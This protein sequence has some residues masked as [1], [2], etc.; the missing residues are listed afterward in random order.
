MPKCCPLTR[1]API[2][3]GEQESDDEPGLGSVAAREY[4]S[5]EDWSRGSR[6]DRE[7]DEHDGREPEDDQGGEAEHEDEEP[8]LGWT[9]EEAACGQYA[10]SWGEGADLE[11]D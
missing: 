4:H 6:D 10:G 2:E 9:D 1:E 7:G 8:S 11:A 3:D 5:Q